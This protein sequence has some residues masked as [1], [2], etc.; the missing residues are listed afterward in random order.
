MN[1]LSLETQ[2]A[3]V[4]QT[5]EQGVSEQP[6]KPAVGD[7]GK[8]VPAAGSAVPQRRAASDGAQR[9]Q[10]SRAVTTLNDYVQSQQR[11]L[12]FSLDSE[13]DRP[14]VRVLDSSTKE[15]IRQIPSEVALRLARNVKASTELSDGESLGGTASAYGR[16]GA[17]TAIRLLDTKA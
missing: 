17:D 11:D 12:Q 16:G 7:S 2:R 8:D 15:V 5:K 10:V 4:P 14:V 3:T 9:E 6:A 13:L 1:E